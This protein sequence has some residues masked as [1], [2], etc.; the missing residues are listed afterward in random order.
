MAGQ[1]WYTYYGHLRTLDPAVP[2]GTWSTTP[3]SRGQYLGESGHSGDPCCVVHLHFEV[4]DS[5]F[6][7]RDPYDLYKTR[8]AYPDPQGTNGKR[9]GPDSL[10]I[11]NPPRRT[12]VAISAPLAALIGADPAAGRRRARRLRRKVRRSA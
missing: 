4:L 7:I 2:I 5:H 8:S 11:S 1:T 6:V 12:A 9:A 10:F 3:V